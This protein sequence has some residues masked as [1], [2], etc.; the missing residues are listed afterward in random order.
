MANEIPVGFATVFGLYIIAL[1]MVS[2]MTGLYQTIGE[3]WE[4]WIRE[5]K[6]NCE[7][8]YS[9]FEDV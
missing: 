3:I 6:T 9:T 2:L 7:K 8:S 1:R 4:T 5:S